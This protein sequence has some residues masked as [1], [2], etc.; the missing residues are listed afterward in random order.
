MEVSIMAES[1]TTTLTREERHAL[2]GRLSDH[3]DGIVN[4][5][6]HGMA[7]DIRLAAAEL[8]AID[9]PRLR[10]TLPALRFELDRIAAACPDAATAKQLRVV[11][12]DRGVTGASTAGSRGERRHLT[13]IRYTPAGELPAGGLQPAAY[14]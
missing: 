7:Q 1:S 3:A 9:P 4:V 13:A 5:A 8:R 2:A 10:A 12:G 11:M 6:A 14:I